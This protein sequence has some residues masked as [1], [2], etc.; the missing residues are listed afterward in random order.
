[1][2][3]KAFVRVVQRQGWDV[4]FIERGA[5]E[6]HASRAEA[7]AAA[8]A[9]NPEWIELGEVVPESE[10]TP[11]HHRWQTLRRTAAGEYEPSGLAWGGPGRGGQVE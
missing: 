7:L 5:K 3:G 10:G 4:E 11:Q 6:N 8:Q 2:T 9:A 1:M